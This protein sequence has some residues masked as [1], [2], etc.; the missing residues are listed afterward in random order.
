MPRKKVPERLLLFN[1]T[2]VQGTGLFPQLSDNPMNQDLSSS[3]A[4][5][6]LYGVDFQSQTRVSPGIAEH[7]EPDN[8]AE[9]DPLIDEAVDPSIDEIFIT[10]LK[11]LAIDNHPFFKTQQSVA[12][13]PNKPTPAKT[14][15]SEQML[16]SM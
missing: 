13:A 8:L 10:R 7:K 6:A 11:N 16:T 5:S 14:K 9:F 4:S 2:T 3:S 15:Q 1:D 12:A